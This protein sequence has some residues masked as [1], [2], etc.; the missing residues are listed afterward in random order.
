MHLYVQYLKC[1]APCMR[2]IS[3]PPLHPVLP[4]T[5]NHFQ[6][7]SASKQWPGIV[8]LVSLFFTTEI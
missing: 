6:N 2:R 7:G 5:F 4:S 3:F 1:N 8:K